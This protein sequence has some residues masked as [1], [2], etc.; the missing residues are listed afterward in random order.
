MST[1]SLFKNGTRLAAVTTDQVIYAG[2]CKLYGIYPELTTTGTITVGDHPTTAATNI[3]HVCA[4]GLDQRGKTFGPD[5]V[6]FQMG[7]VIDLSVGT[8]QALV[9]WE[10]V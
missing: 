10:P 5:G 4:I 6:L 9:V 7:L 8:D 1:N 3:K 2:R